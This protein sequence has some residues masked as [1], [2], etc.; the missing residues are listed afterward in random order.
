MTPAPPK[1]V[2]IR[3]KAGVWKTRLAKRMVDNLVRRLD[4]AQQRRSLY[5]RLLWIPPRD[6]KTK[7]GPDNA[8][9]TLNQW[10]LSNL[11]FSLREA[12]TQTFW[13]RIAATMVGFQ[14]RRLVQRH[15][16]ELACMAFVGFCSDIIVFREK[17]LDWLA[18]NHQELTGDSGLSAELLDA[19]SF[20]HRGPD[21][22]VLEDHCIYLTYRI[23]SEACFALQIPGRNLSC[24]L[25]IEVN[26]VPLEST[27]PDSVCDCSTRRLATS[28]VHRERT[29][30]Q[31]WR[32]GLKSGLH[33]AVFPL[34]EVVELQ[35]QADEDLRP[36]LNTS[37]LDFTLKQ[38]IPP[39][40]FVVVLGRS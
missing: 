30:A 18:R 36:L 15:V 13:L 40:E 32:N 12:A 23:M 5:A 11:F 26:R 25:S 17:D 22:D 16:G 21:G 8:N 34:L 33:V 20:L 4:D 1:R 24:S 35:N 28:W 9:I 37:E 39:Q 10:L 14:R 6:L 29:D 27:K 31:T 7:C 3:G 2:L 19:S 38:I